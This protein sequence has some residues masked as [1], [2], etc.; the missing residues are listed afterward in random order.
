MW[1]EPVQVP[2]TVGLGPRL[3]G[4][5]FD[6]GFATPPGGE[7]GSPYHV[8]NDHT[9][10]CTLGLQV[11][12][13][14][15]PT[16]AYASQCESWHNKRLHHRNQDAERLGLP[17][18]ISEFGAC[19]TEDNCTQEINQ[20]TN[21]ADYY[22]V[23]WAYWEFKTYKDLTTS[24]GTGEEG[25]YNHDGSLQAW[26]AKAL[27]RTY[28]MKTQGANDSF[29]FDMK[30]SEFSATFK[31]DTSIEAAT[32]LYASTEFYYPN[33]KQVSISVDGV[34][35]A[36]SQVE[37]DSSSANIY[38]FRV[39]DAALNGQTVTVRCTQ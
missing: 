16:T 12:A 13:T 24:A 34:Q 36:D 37:V 25:F 8:L 3:P 33:G 6:V 30:T 27:A 7:V 9:Y 22:S 32:E 17:L 5:I 19:L 23:G 38:K 21:A 2:D 35:L 20:V 14:G 26:K 10:C 31:V 18:F 29:H 39:T 11:C 28:L 4:Q 15:E 1:F